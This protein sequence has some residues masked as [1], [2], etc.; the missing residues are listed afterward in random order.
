MIEKVTDGDY[1]AQPIAIAGEAICNSSLVQLP[2]LT[3]GVD[4]RMLE[5]KP[6]H[7]SDGDLNLFKKE[8]RRL[9]NP[10]H[11]LRAGQFYLSGKFHTH[12]LHT[13]PEFIAQSGRAI[14]SHQEVESPVDLTILTSFSLQGGL[15]DRLADD[16]IL[17]IFRDITI[18]IDNV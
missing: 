6:G 11:Q 5:S 2:R 12:D 4:G 3:R 10:H 16:G 15:S 9:A 7:D 1:R 8:G 18:K 17:I 14:A 13:G